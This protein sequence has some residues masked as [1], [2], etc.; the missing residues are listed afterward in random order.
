MADKVA[1]AIK[2]A[3]KTFA[4]VLCGF[5]PEGS[6]PEEFADFAYRNVSSTE[7]L[8]TVKKVTAIGIYQDADPVQLAERLTQNLLA[9]GL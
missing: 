9:T 3:G 4:I 2:P 1:G 7:A 5:F 8:A 6:T